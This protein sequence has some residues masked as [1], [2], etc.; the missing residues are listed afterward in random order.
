MHPTGELIT[1]R[2]FDP[3]EQV[4]LTEPSLEWPHG[5][6]ALR[7]APAWRHQ[8][9]TGLSVADSTFRH[10]L[11]PMTLVIGGQREATA[12]ALCRQRGWP[13]D[14][15]LTALADAADDLLTPVVSIVSVEHV[16][17]AFHA[18]ISGLRDDSPR[19]WRPT[20]AVRRIKDD[21]RAL[22]LLFDARTVS[23]DL[24]ELDWD[25]VVFHAGRERF[26][27][28]GD[29]ELLN[30][31]VFRIKRDAES[32]LRREARVR[33]ALKTRAEFLAAAASVRAAQWAVALAAI[34]I[35]VALLAL[36]AGK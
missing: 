4:E 31:A 15:A 12:L 35:L 30:E 2:M 20:R 27:R 26:V 13:E 10:S 16:A 24:R 29:S 25:L 8:S 21:M 5:R 23:A 14:G 33:E 17:R 32:I 36:V 22:P 34:A 28:H 19:T 11:D 6:L 1:A 7:F 9:T 18:H 3:F